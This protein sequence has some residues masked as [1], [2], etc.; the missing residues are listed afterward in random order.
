MPSSRNFVLTG[1]H[2]PGQLGLPEEPGGRGIRDAAVS[3]EQSD[4]L[5][6]L[7]A[8]GREDGI[9]ARVDAR[10]RVGAAFE[11]HRGHF[12]FPVRRTVL[13]RHSPRKRRD[14][15]LREPHP[16]VRIEAKAEE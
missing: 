7:L 1:E 5:P 6:V 9:A 10:V 2:L 15:S 3:F 14:V 12:V 8:V 13:E 16:L 11:Q 4:H